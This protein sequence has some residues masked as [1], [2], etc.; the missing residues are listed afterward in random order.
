MRNS[1]CRITF[2]YFL[3]QVC[4][5]I[6]VSL[7]EINVV[8]LKEICEQLEVRTSGGVGILTSDLRR[9]NAGTEVL[10]LKAL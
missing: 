3:A 7:R 1:S 8:A 2:N 9:L 6:E 10:L 4:G 5:V